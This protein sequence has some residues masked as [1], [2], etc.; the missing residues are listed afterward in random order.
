MLTKHK[1]E[2]FIQERKAGEKHDKIIIY[3]SAGSG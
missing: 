2:Y 3:D 1:P